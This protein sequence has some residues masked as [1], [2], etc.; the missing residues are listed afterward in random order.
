YPDGR[1]PR[2][3]GGCTGTRPPRFRLS[4]SPGNRCRPAGR[5]RGLRSIVSRHGMVN[6]AEVGILRPSMRP[7]R[8]DPGWANDPP[9]TPVAPEIG[10]YNIGGNQG[11][12]PPVVVGPEFVWKSAVTRLG[13]RGSGHVPQ[14]L[15]MDV[16]AG[17][18]LGRS[19][20]IGPVPAPGAGSRAT[21]SPR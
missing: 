2:R 3:G 5:S 9:I 4:Q 8:S 11:T 17:R 21:D 18:C 12:R 13:P 1:G 20:D 15:S 16:F 6:D 19:R 7:L 10:G 14:T